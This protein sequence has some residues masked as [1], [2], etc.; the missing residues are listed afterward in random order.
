[1][2]AIIRVDASLNIG[3]GHVMRCL[4]LSNALKNKGVLVE[5]I[6]RAHKGNLIEFLRQNGFKVHVLGLNT[7]KDVAID[8]EYSQSH[9]EWLG[10]PSR[11]DAL[12]CIGILDGIRPD[13]LIVDHYAI[14][15]NWQEELKGTYNKLMVIDDLADRYHECDILLDQTLGRRREDYKE[16]VPDSC[17]ILV[18]PQ[19][20][21][22]RPEFTK[23][24]DFSL[25]RKA[26]L[27]TRKLL[28]TLGG[29]DKDNV[30]GQVL[31]ELMYCELLSYM[32]V[33]VVMGGNAPHID[34]IK[35]QIDCLPY[36]VQLKVDVN[37]MAEIMANSDLAIGAAGATTWER[38]CLGLPSIQIT[39]AQNQELIAEQ[40]ELAG[41]SLS[42]DVTKLGML[43]QQ[44]TSLIENVNDISNSAAKITSGEGVKEVMKYLL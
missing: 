4:T 15:K 28:I 12:D 35:Q 21:V 23:W 11:Q 27:E 17:H 25:A 8:Y 3:T 40:V 37:N 26:K 5:F 1:M 24:R 36:K 10:V 43:C 9:K 33:T 14:G 29:V 22:L 20:A 18:G 34:K 30:T 32:D 2:K 38:C 7:S 13:W 39:I 16:L 41:A 44:L 31:K 42:L 6:C 19:Y